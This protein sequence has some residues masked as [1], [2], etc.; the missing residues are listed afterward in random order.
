MN[1]KKVVIFVLL[2]SSTWGFSNHNPGNDEI[3]PENNDDD[4]RNND[5]INPENDNVLSSSDEND[6]GKSELKT[7][8]L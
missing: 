6:D 1:F 3:D 2:F 4:P 8:N 5:K 7:Y